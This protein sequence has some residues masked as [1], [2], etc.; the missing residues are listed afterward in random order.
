MKPNDFIQSNG[1]R[2]AFYGWG[3]ED[4]DM[5]RRG[6]IWNRN[7][8]IKAPNVTESN[9]CYHIQHPRSRDKNWRF[10]YDN[11][12]RVF[13]M[14]HELKGNK[15]KKY[16]IKNFNTGVTDLLKHKYFNIIKNE[17]IYEN[18]NE[19]KYINQLYVNLNS[20][21][22]NKTVSL[23]K[24]K[25]LLMQYGWYYNNSKLLFN[26]SIANQSVLNSQIF[27]A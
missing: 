20:S 14:V 21:I 6:N 1:Y 16:I 26:Q 17:I 12:G 8:W 18:I 2:N 24:N 25:E 19:N 3:F 13:N 23:W 10:G 4:D 27:Y 22:Y 7:I 5:C 15:Y 9:V 11:N